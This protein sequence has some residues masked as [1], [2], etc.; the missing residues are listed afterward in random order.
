MVEKIERRTGVEIPLV[1]FDSIDAGYILIL[2][3]I[4][5]TIM[6]ERIWINRVNREIVFNTVRDDQ[7]HLDS[8]QQDITDGM[9]SL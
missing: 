2:S 6:P 1:F 3:E 5:I 7:V 8:H 4:H 9:Q